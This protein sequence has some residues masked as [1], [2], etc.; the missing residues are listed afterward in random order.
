MTARTAV[1]IVSLGLALGTTACMDFYEVPV[2]VPIQAKLD[3]STF[4][5]VLVAGFLSGG[6]K[7]IYP[8]TETARLLRSQLRTKSDLKVID[9]DVLS[10]VE[11]VD[12]RA[13]G[14]TGASTEGL[15]AAN[16]DAASNEPKIKNSKDMEAYEAIF[17]DKDYWKKLGEE[18]QSPLIVTGSV[19]FTEVAKSGMVSTIQPQ[20]DPTGVVTYKEVQQFRDQRG[21]ALDQKFVFIDGRTGALL[22]SETLHSD[23]YYPATQNTPA[24]SAYFELMD[25]LLPTFLTTLNTQRIRGTRI[26]IK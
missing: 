8:N 14:N 10:L 20:A 13:S 3:V 4:K 21:F 11:E 24:L 25:K 6:S 7:A 5:R 19:L 16:P 18:Y 15:V 9:A 22:H 2:D 23:A 26:L 1:G 12:R 17:N